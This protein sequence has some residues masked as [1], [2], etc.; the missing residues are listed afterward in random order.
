VLGL[1]SG[2]ALWVNQ[3]A[4]PYFLTMA[5]LLAWQHDDRRGW[6]ALV[7]GFVLGASLLLVHNV[8]YPLATARALV[9][10]AV[11]LNRVPVEER[12]EAWIARGMGKRVEA[13]SH[14]AGKLGLVFGVPPAGDIERLGLSAAMREGGPLTDLRRRL[15]PIPLLIFGVALV[16]CRPRRGRAGWGPPSSNQL[17]AI[18]FLVTFAVGYV[19]PRYMLPAYPLAAVA[20]GVLAARTRGGARRATVVGIAAVLVF[21]AASWADSTRLLGAGDGESAEKLLA[22]LEARDLRRCYAAGPLYHLVFASEERVILAPLQKD[23]YPP[24]DAQIESADRICY[25]YRTDQ[26]E[27]RQHV[28]MMGFLG[29]NGISYDNFE[30]GP[31]RVL[32]GFSRREALTPS[33]IA[34]IRNQEKAHVEIAP[35]F[36][37]GDNAS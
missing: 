15:W 22:E 19:S 29:E 16:A 14:G 5:G 36:G 17:L 13:I 34:S 10:K 25:V 1:V 24:Y 23:R 32:H 2:I 3:L 4:L 21:N 35:I 7:V 37:Q 18:M 8:N 6:P 33:V 9:R 26:A 28:A 27:K 12:D 31:Y 20:V 30:A 11:V